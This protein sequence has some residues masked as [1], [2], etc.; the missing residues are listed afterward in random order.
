ALVLVAGE[1][2]TQDA[3]WA[4]VQGLAEPAAKEAE[5]MREEVRAGIAAQTYA[6]PVLWTRLAVFFKVLALGAGVIFV[7]AGRNDP[8]DEHAGEYQG[9]LLLIV[10]G[11]SLVGSANDL[12]T[13]FLALELVS[14]PTYILLYLP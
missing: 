8:Y 11:T 5:T 12:I 9:C 10:A 6:A 3:S 14:I 7:L 4:A 1:L 2:S 13:L